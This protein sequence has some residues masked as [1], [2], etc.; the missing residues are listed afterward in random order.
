[1]TTSVTALRV[2]LISAVINKDSS[3]VLRYVLFVIIFIILDICIYVLPHHN[4]T[5]TNPYPHL[6][7]INRTVIPPHDSLSVVPLGS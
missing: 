4:P 7:N 2:L 3:S 6:A 1:M 5:I